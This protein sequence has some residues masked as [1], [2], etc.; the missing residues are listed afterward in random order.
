MAK[1]GEIIFEKL[2][3]FYPGGTRSLPR[4][5]RGHAPRRPNAGLRRAST[6]H[7]Q[8]LKIFEDLPA[9]AAVTTPRARVCAEGPET[10]GVHGAAW[11]SGPRT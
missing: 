10:P 2:R 3:I 4:T 9:R 1:K 6:Q 8:N 5:D 7:F 11:R